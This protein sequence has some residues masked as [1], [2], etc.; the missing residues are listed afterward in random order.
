METLR[1]VDLFFPN[2]V[3]CR[4]VT[5]ATDAAAGLRALQNGRTRTS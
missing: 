1:E 5:G 3:E 4:A 2:E